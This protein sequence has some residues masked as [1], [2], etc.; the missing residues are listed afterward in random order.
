[1]PG[2]V[3]GS[4]GVKGILRLWLRFALANRNLRSE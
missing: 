2:V 4:E 1:M 3:A